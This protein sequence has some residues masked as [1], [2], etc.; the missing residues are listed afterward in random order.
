MDN[1][2]RLKRNIKKYYLFEA[3]NSLAFFSPVIVLFWQSK[4]LNM[5]QILTLQSI[6]AIGALVLELPTGGFADYF[7][8]KLSL[9]FGS[10]FF[11]LG[12]FWYGLSSH[13]WQFAIGELTCAT[14]MAFISGADRAFIH[15][16]LKSLGREKDYTKTEGAV[17]GL[18]QVFQALG[19]IGGGFIGSIS[20]GLTLI[21]TG[22]STLIAFLVSLSFSKTKIELP[23]EEK[24]NYLQI[25]KES[26]K[27]VKSDSEVLWLTLFFA[28]INSLVFATNWFSQPYLQMLKVPIVYF[29][30]IFASF[31]L[32]SAFCSTQTDKL[33]LW[34]KDKVFIVISLFAV[35]SIFILGAF[36]S[37]FI[38]P[39][40]SI[41]SI[42][43]VVNQTLIGEKTLALIPSERAATIL[44]FQS[45]IRRLIYAIF[46]PFLGMVSDH[47]GIRMAMQFNALFLAVLLIIIFVFKQT[48]KRGVNQPK[49]V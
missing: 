15:Q 32:V 2:A 26:F 22:F 46:I 19:N 49:T 12:L 1:D 25:L 4:G 27:I 9:I 28:I 41:F 16:T 29:G 42:I 34:L 38:I 8:K 5:T 11:S 21:A 43:T 14:G 10:L 37:V 23:S 3:F 48:S 36:P 18:N 24:T 39:L 7:G 6:Y 13:F 44:S 33:G 40:F 31:S 45:L 47:F 30:F 35:F 17:R 20:L